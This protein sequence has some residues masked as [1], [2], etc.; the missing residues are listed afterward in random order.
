VIVSGVRRGKAVTI[1]GRAFTY[2]IFWNLSKY[3]F[4]HRCI[5]KEVHWSTNLL[6]DVL[7]FLYLLHELRT[8][9]VIEFWKIIHMVAPE[10]TRIFEFSMALLIAETTSYAPNLKP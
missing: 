6:K 10:T 8:L 3:I 5:S 4:T 7:G 9:Y 1:L 2:N